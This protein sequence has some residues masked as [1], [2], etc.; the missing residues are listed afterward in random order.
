MSQSNEKAL[1]EELRKDLESLLNDDLNFQST[2]GNSELT[3]NNGGVELGEKMMH[4]NAVPTDFHKLRE[5]AA[6]DAKKTLTSLVKFYLGAKIIKKN[7]YNKYKKKFDEM[8]LANMMFAIEVGQVAIIKLLEDIDMGN[9]HPRNFEAL[10]TLNGQ[11]MNMVKHQQALFITMEEGY[12]KIKSD[13]EEIEAKDDSQVE[14][15][16]VEDITN[17]SGS[18]KSRG[19]KALM[20]N[21]QKNIKANT[22]E[23]IKDTNHVSL[24]D[25]YNRPDNK[26]YTAP[27]KQ[28]TT[29]SDDIYDDLD[30]HW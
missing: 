2:S 20:A 9:T 30:E 18:Y 1:Q 26:I 8:S 15:T 23:I 5:A 25:P 24:T 12:K 10:A 6:V 11:M 27:T 22:I 13:Y 17:I 29:E 28:N 21:I 16:E 4:P 3:L 19:T 14:E 7:E